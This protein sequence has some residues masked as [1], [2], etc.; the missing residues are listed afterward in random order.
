MKIGDIRYKP[1]FNNDNNGIPYKAISTKVTVTEIIEDKEGLSY[2]LQS[3]SKEHATA[4]ENIILEETFDNPDDAVKSAQDK[5]KSMLEAAR[6][7]VTEAINV[8][9]SKKEMIDNR[10]KNIK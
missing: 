9:E 5:H 3:E 7:Q 2:T 8:L 1:D 6:K 4:R 10:L